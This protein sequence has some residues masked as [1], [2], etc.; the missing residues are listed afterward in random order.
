VL[1]SNWLTTLPLLL[2]VGGAAAS[3]HPGP[4][5]GEAQYNSRTVYCLDRYLGSGTAVHQI[6]WIISLAIEKQ[7]NMLL[8]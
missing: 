4:H 2:Q 3:A 7:Y 6:A 5:G 8:A 1:F